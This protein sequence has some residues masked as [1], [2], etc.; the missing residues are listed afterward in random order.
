[1]YEGINEELMRIKERMRERDRLKNLLKKNQD[2]LTEEKHR[3]EEL[4]KVLEKEERDL[5]KVES[6]SLTGL[7]YSILGSRE[8]QVEKERQ[9]ALAAKLKYDESTKSVEELERRISELV[10]QL[11]AFEGIDEQYSRVLAE[12]EKLLASSGGEGAARLLQY[13]EKMAELRADIKELEEAIHAGKRVEQELSKVVSALESAGNWGTWD[14]LGG[15]FLATAAKHSKI[16][17]AREYADNVQHLLR[18]FGHELADV[19]GRSNLSIDIGTFAVFADYF[20][21]GLIS[22]WVVQSRINESLN[23]ARSLSEDVRAIIRELD[24]RRRE[25][26]ARLEALSAERKK[27]LEEI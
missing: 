5:H 7:F 17:E 25:S 12:K 6:L 3:Q 18:D 8:Q 11:A 22:D 20:F 9:E 26:T 14:M 24:A 15:G 27:L 10:R 19:G 16:D 21:D 13:S 2:S 1:M 23:R 4:W